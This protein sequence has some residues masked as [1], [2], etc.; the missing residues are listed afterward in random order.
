[1]GG[2]GGGLLRADNA[3]RLI[4]DNVKYRQLC[5]IGLLLIGLEVL[6][7]EGGRKENRRGG[8]TEIKGSRRMVLHLQYNLY[9]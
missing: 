1:M 2:F 5:Y 3:V 6:R 9:E 8:I 7:K 4:S